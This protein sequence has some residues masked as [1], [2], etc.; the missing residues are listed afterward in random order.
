MERLFGFG[1][2]C[3]NFVVLHMYKYIYYQ[4]YAGKRMTWEGF[5]GR[6]SFFR[7]IESSIAD[8][9]PHFVKHLSKWNAIEEFLD[10]G[11]GRND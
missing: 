6:M 10:D 1:A 5:R 7:K 11:N 8:Q 4:N 2:E 9:S 3:E